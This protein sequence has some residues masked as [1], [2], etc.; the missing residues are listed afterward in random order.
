MVPVIDFYMVI[1]KMTPH[2]RVGDDISRSRVATTVFVS[3]DYARGGQ[4]TIA[5]VKADLVEVTKSGS[6]GRDQPGRSDQ[7][8]VVIVRGFPS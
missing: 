4:V 3:C 6:S 2:F 8:R 1:T 5:M 7:V